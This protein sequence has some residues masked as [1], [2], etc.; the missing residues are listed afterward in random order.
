MNSKQLR[1]NLTNTMRRLNTGD[2]S[3][4]EAREMTKAAS[5][6]NQ[7][8]RFD[9][10]NKRENIKLM[11]ALGKKSYKDIAPTALKLY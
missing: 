6:I 3:I 2:A 9:I 5:A 11:K 10:E 7:S 8:L 1:F 4:R